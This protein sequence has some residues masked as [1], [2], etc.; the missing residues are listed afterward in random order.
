MNVAVVV[1]HPD[2]EILWCGGTI[3][4]NP[5]WKCFILAL[6]RASDPDRAPKFTRA[7]D[8]LGA[9]G[10][11]ADLD[12]GAEQKPVRTETVQHTILS[13]LPDAHYDLLITHSPDGEYT[14]HRRHE[15]TAEGIIR[16]WHAHEIKIK[17][18]WC[19]AYNDN[20][21]RHLPRAIETAPVYR[22]LED[23]TWRRK[24]DIITSIYGFGKDSFEAK[25]TPKA[26]AFW[27]FT[28]FD[29]AF[30]WLSKSGDTR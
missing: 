26:E 13:H 27:R 17:E 14:R 25:T 16:L 21:S 9:N 10:C 12:D 8:K 30:E 19:F 22:I 23:L 1:A 5:A 15:E 18:L 6:C 3:L 28:R 24:Y 4:D 7:L 11:L 20:R 2:D 29:E